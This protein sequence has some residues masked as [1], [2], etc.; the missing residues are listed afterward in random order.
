MHLPAIAYAYFREC[1]K[2]PIFEHSFIPIFCHC[3][4]VRAVF[5]LFHMNWFNCRVFTFFHVQKL[6]KII[7]CRRHFALQWTCPLSLSLS[8]AVFSVYLIQAI[9]NQLECVCVIDIWSNRIAKK[10]RNT[11]TP[12]WNF[13]WQS[14]WNIMLLLLLLFPYLS[15]LRLY[16]FK[17]ILILIYLESQ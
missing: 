3:T 15:L 1:Q 8:I 13:L 16:S 2:M 6:H 17:I 12:H 4:R 9:V 11:H 10:K 7:F 14:Q 5:S